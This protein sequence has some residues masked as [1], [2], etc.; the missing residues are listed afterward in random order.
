[1]A[2]LGA[3][4]ERKI[5]EI[6]SSSHGVVTRAELLGAGLSVHEIRHRVWAGA[7]I[8]EY[9]GVYRVGHRAPSVEAR[10]LAAVRASGE[11]AALRGRAA[12]FLVGILKGSPPLPEVITPTQRRIP[13]LDTRFSR[14]IDPRDVTTVRGIPVTTVPRTLVDLAAVLSLHA[15]ARA[16]HEAGVRYRTTPRHVEAVLAR[17]PNT[18]GAANLRRVTGGDVDVLLSKMEKIFPKRLRKAGLP[19]PVTNRPAGGRRVDCRWPDRDPP[20]TVELLSYQVHNSRYAWEMDR[21]RER[22]ARKRGD[23]FRTYDWRD[24]VE[25]PRYMLN[26]LRILLLGRS[27]L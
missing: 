18:P 2:H 25:D 24:V 15:L 23:D 17:R 1:M 13:G 5:A 10:Y 7:L 8:R 3:T 26:E 20:L 4:A 6:A 12:G 22:E 11:G 16:C 9:K 19:L 21:R 27:E 14:R